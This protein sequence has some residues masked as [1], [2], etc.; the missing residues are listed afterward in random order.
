M[1]N[2]SLA[3]KPAYPRWWEKQAKCQEVKD[4]CQHSWNKCIVMMTQWG[5]FRLKRNIIVKLESFQAN[6]QIILFEKNILNKAINRSLL[7]D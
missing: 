1:L 4:I 2:G 3:A 6:S 5:A 7:L